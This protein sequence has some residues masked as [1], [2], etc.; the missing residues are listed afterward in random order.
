MKETSGRSGA[1]ERD[2]MGNENL[3]RFAIPTAAWFQSDPLF[4]VMG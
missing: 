3:F 1:A 2:G 4:F